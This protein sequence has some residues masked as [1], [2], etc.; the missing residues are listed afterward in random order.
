MAAISWDEL[1]RLPGGEA[2][3]RRELGEV[4]PARVL[5]TAPADANDIFAAQL[6][7]ADVP[8]FEREVDTP[9]PELKHEPCDGTGTTKR[10]TKCGPC[11]GTGVRRPAWRVDFAWARERVIVEVEGGVHAIKAQHESDVRKRRWL[12]RT[13]WLV[14]P[15]LTSEVRD[16][17]AVAEIETFFRER[18]TAGAAGEGRNGC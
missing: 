3:A 2:I 10:A 9:G 16:K 7:A 11:G 14:L 15:V 6:A 5:N 18:S 17:S 12:A 1:R 13:G 4:G 8:P